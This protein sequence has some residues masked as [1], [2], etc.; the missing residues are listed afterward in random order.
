MA[1]SN[2]PEFAKHI[3]GAADEFRRLSIE[4]ADL[5]AKKILN[6]Y[7][8]VRALKPSCLVETGIANGV[9]SS[10]FLLALQKNGKGQ[11]QSLGLADPAYLP[12]GKN[13]GWLVPGWLRSSW[14]VHLGDS[15]ELL[16]NLLA[17]ISQLSIFIHDSLHTY[18]HMM[19]EFQAVYPH[20]Q[21]ELLADDALWNTSFNDFA[22]QVHASRR[23]V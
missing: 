21:A 6:Q 18:E 14:N 12:L 1:S 16:P 7:A 3:D 8:A 9:S 20:L 23:A 17:Q 5:Y 2:T 4:S 22:K 15:R 19:W 10:Y 11:L 13:P